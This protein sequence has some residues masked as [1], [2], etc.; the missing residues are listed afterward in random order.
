MAVK[1]A[2]EFMLYTGV[3]TDL[4]GTHNCKPKTCFESFVLEGQ[5]SEPDTPFEGVACGSMLKISTAKVARFKNFKA[6]ITTFS[7]VTKES[8]PINVFVSSKPR[9]CESIEVVM[10]IEQTE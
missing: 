5:N 4:T 6:K 2:A 7:D 1:S 10:T 3:F 8:N 9:F